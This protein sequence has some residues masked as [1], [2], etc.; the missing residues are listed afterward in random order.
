MINEK[1][2]IAGCLKGDRF[3]QEKLYQ[4]YA[5]KMLGICLRYTPDRSAAEDILQEGFIKVFQNLEK[6]RHEGSFEGWI[7]RIMVNTSLERYRK[8]NRLYSVVDI[9]EVENDVSTENFSIENFAA[10]DL[11][12]IIQSLN[13]G[14]RTVFN[15]YAIEGYSHKE[16]A[17]QLGISEGTSK[18]Q[19]SRARTILQEMVKKNELI[20][21][22]VNAR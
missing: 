13:P 15:L 3:S 4:L 17:G 19:L 21:E 10:K 16:I 22:S 14:Y 11:L 2:I 20:N 9:E 18:S 1:D 12:K 7:K 8:N 6:F 5:G